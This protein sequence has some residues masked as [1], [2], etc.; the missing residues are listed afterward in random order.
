MARD[1]FPMSSRSRNVKVSDTTKSHVK[2]EADA[3]VESV[4]KK[5]HI[6]PPPKDAHF[7]YLVD[8]FTKWRGHRF[9]FYAKYHCPGSG[10]ISPSFETGFARMEY[11]GYDTFSLAYMRH[12]GKWWTIYPELSLEECLTAIK[13]EPPFLP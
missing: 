9:Y 7:N 11:I 5:R 13:E 12:T 8:I 6:E 10:A 3:L 4:L 1:W 2:R